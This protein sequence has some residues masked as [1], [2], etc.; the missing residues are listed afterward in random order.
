MNCVVKA[1]VEP[2]ARVLY[3]EM[4]KAGFENVID[5]IPD[6]KG[7]WAFLK[8][9]AETGACISCRDG[10]GD[11]GC[12]IRIC[13]KE[14]GVEM[15]VFCAEYPCALFKEFSETRPMLVKDNT[16]LL[17]KGWDAWLKMQDERRAKGYTFGSKE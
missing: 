3:D 6:G 17:E 2:A 11:P 16:L 13:A 5:F 14:K 4:Y 15:C 10:S 1:K 9:M 7:F 8:G 12:K